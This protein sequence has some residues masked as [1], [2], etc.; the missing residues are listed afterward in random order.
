MFLSHQE[1]LLM[2]DID[3]ARERL[4][5]FEAMLRDHMR[6]EE[7]HLLPLY[8]RAGPVRGGPVEFFL[9]EHRKM[10]E[11]LYRFSQRLEQLAKSKSDLKREVIKLFDAEAT[12][13]HLVEHH[14]LREQNILYPALDRV[15]TEKERASMLDR[16]PV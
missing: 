4:R 6:F 2:L 16:R 8:R 13:K 10:L 15:T 11:F 12:F 7:E 1:A 14:D 9:G 5:R 3:L